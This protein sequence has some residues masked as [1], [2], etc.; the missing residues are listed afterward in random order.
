MFGLPE[1]VDLSFL[2]DATLLQVCLG[3]S[4]TILHLEP[5]ISMMVASVMILEIAGEERREFDSTADCAKFVVPLLGQSVVGVGGQPDGRLT[6]EW[7]SGARLEILDSYE[8]F[9]S[10]TIRQGTTLIVV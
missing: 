1:D 7:S 10:Y 3:E 6:L 9:E 4:E 5:G 8:E 2:V